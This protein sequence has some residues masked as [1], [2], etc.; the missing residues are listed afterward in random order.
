MSV[1]TGYDQRQQRKTQFVISLPTLLEQHRMNVAF[2]MIH[3]DQ[4]LVESKSQRLGIADADKKRS[5][6]P[7]TLGHGHRVHRLV[8][9]SRI[10]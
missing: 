9:M 1:A 10:S 3:R 4:R 8:S 6:K 7:R 5:S 2:E